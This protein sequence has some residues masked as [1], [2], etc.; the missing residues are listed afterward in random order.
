MASSLQIS[1]MFWQNSA[2]KAVPSACS[3]YPP[4]GSGEL[5]SNTPMLSRPRKP[6]SNTLFPVRSLRFTHQV[7]L[8]SSWGKGGGEPVEIALAA[9]RL[10]QP[11][12]E[13]RRP[14]MHGGI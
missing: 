9:L 2:I 12:S 3:R 5:R 6:P 7:K 13:D 11:V 8:S 4:V 10:L 1:S 14:R